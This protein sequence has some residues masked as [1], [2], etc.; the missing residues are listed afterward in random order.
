[1]PDRESVG[2][3]ALSLSSDVDTHA[4]YR[5]TNPDASGG[6]LSPRAIRGAFE[7]PPNLNAP[8][9]RA[10]SRRTA[11]DEMAGSR[12]SAVTRALFGAL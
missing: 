9:T 3:P 5:E 7:D 2:F 4:E 11:A 6:E 10:V 1:M 8:P 12:N